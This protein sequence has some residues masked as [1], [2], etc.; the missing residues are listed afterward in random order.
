MTGCEAIQALKDGKRVRQSEWN[1]DCYL[2]AYY[3]EK[4]GWLFEPSCAFYDLFYTDIP[5]SQCCVLDNMIAVA[6]SL[7]MEDNWEV[8]I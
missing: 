3:T 8:V 6:A 5:I 2:E 1:E 4:A 7:F